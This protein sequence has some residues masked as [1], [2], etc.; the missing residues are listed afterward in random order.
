MSQREPQTLD[1]LQDYV[2]EIAEAYNSYADQNNSDIRVLNGRTHDLFAKIN[3][4]D[5]DTALFVQDLLRR[6]QKATMRIKELEARQAQQDT[7]YL[8]LAELGEN[9]KE[10]RQ[11]V[12][13][14][15]T[16][17][18]YI[19]EK[20]L[21]D[22]DRSRPEAESRGYQTGRQTADRQTDRQ[23]DEFIRHLKLQEPTM[24]VR[25]ISEILERHRGVKVGKDKVAAIIKR[26][27]LEGKL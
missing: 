2:Y 10:L 23:L 27:E 5:S 15:P 7:I 9:I 19:T 21:S 3:D 18:R 11:I 12:G 6:L 16:P 4:L 20:P 22:N 26:L 8:A 13:K 24:S 1:E 17:F 14:P 25:K